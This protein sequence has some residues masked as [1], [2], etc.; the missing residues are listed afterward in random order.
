MF[1]VGLTPPGVHSKTR[2][3]GLPSISSLKKVLFVCYTSDM[4]NTALSNWLLLPICFIFVWALIIIGAI[5][6]GSSLVNL[7]HLGNFVVANCLALIVSFVLLSVYGDNQQ[8]RF[9][10]I[11]LA[12][13][14]VIGTATGTYITVR[15]L[16]S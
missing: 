8:K 1:P 15:W 4:K 2:T 10:Y 13:I 16:N 11:A 6:N 3:T 7:T 9:S 12:T 14:V 5:V